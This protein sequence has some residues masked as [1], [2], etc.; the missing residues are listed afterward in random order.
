VE[1]ITSKPKSVMLATRVTPLINDIVD[2]MARRE[3]LN[4]SEW[5][6]NLIIAELKRSEALPDLK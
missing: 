5:I 1:K 2:Q 6:R 4:K 3:G